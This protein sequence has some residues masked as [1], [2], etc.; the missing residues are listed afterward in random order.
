MR[1]KTKIYSAL[2]LAHSCEQEQ[3]SI[4]FTK[5]YGEMQMISLNWE[6]VNVNY[7]NVEYGNLFVEFL[8][9]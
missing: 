5:G 7:G 9:F 6:F 8:A 1:P 3:A 4:T 2:L